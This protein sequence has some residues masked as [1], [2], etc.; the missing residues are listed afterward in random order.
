MKD[1]KKIIK[2]Y[3]PPISRDDKA[4]LREK[5]IDYKKKT[6]VSDYHIDAA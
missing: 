6:R 3:R 2:K 4:M 5:R 1:S